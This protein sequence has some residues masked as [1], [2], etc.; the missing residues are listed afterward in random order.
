MGYWQVLALSGPVRRERAAEA[1][2][3]M[4]PSGLQPWGPRHAVL[5][6]AG[7]EPGRMICAWSH[8]DCNWPPRLSGRTRRESWG[9]KLWRGSPALTFFNSRGRFACLLLFEAKPGG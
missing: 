2:G 9:A 6:R 8:L 5:W 1:S 7:A 4:S 3:L